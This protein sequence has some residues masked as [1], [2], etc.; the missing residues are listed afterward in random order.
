MALFRV[1]FDIG[2]SSAV[3]RAENREAAIEKVWNALSELRHRAVEELSLGS[4][5]VSGEHTVELDESNQEGKSRQGFV[6]AAH[7][8][9]ERPPSA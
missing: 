4:Y 7:A 9:A 8:N 5:M 6:G 1:F 2:W 3:V